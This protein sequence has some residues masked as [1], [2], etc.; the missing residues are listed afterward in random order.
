MEGV[1]SRG[2]GGRDL[3]RQA[4]S[5]PRRL[6]GEAPLHREGQLNGLG[7]TDDAHLYG[8]QRI[9]HALTTRIQVGMLP[10]APL[11]TASFYATGTHALPLRMGASD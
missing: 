10:K 9:N 8:L 11:W 1:C 2:G 5:V 3:A 6:E 7:S 4:S